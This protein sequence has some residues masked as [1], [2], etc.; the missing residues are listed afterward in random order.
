MAPND[1]LLRITT[2]TN[3]GTD[4][5]F[6][7]GEQP[8][9]QSLSIG[10]EP[11]GIVEKLGS[12]VSGFQEGRRVIAGASTPSGYSNACLCG[13]CTQDGQNDEHGFRPA[14]GCHFGNTIDG[15]QA[16]H[17]LVPDAKANLASIPIGLS[18]RCSK[19]NEGAVVEAAL[20]DRLEL[21]DLNGLTIRKFRHDFK[22]TA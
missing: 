19:F 2:T 3:C 22:L 8:V 20:L 9:K 11:V 7:K 1:A 12:E 5:H 10:H 13:Q 14:G 17:F 4:I 16:E 6:L 21:G 15:A 18:R